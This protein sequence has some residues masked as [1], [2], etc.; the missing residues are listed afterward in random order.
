MLNRGVFRTSQASKMYTFAKIVKK[1]LHLRRL[2][3]SWNTSGIDVPCSFIILFCISS[4]W[5]IRL[6]ITNNTRDNLKQISQRCGWR[7]FKWLNLFSTNVPL[8]YPQK[9]S[10]NLRFSDILRGYRSGTLVENGLKTVRY[11]V[12]SV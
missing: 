12:E 2:T 5:K 9:T 1:K 8:L 3:E 7:N 4:P 6:N 10:E 11:T